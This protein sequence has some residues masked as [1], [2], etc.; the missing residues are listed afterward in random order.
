MVA[1]VGCKN[2]QVS[3]LENVTIDQDYHNQDSNIHSFQTSFETRY[4]A[5]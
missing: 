1:A 4:Q 5:L 2:L 3:V